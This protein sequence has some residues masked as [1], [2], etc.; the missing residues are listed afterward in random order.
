MTC[1]H[2]IVN[3][4]PY[5]YVLYEPYLLILSHLIL[6]YPTLSYLI[7][8]SLPPFL[9]YQPH[10]STSPL[11]SPFQF[12]PSFLFWFPFHSPL[13]YPSRRVT[14][15]ERASEDLRCQLVET[16]RTLDSLS[17]SHIAVSRK[18]IKICYL[19]ISLYHIRLCERSVLHILDGVYSTLSLSHFPFPNIF[20][21]LILHSILTIIFSNYN[22]YC[23]TYYQE[24]TSYAADRLS[25]QTELNDLTNQIISLKKELTEVQ[26]EL[27][28]KSSE[29]D[30]VQDKLLS[31]SEEE[32]R[33]REGLLQQVQ[34]MTCELL[35]LR[36]RVSRQGWWSY[37]W[38][39]WF[40][41]NI[42]LI[43]SHFILPLFNWMYCAD[44]AH[45]KAPHL[46]QVHV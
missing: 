23:F 34:E 36:N 3:E 42:G 33:V 22:H 31:E 44:V 7:F 28:L 9:F 32:S 12:F 21:W 25:L 46:S 45:L 16:Q 30:A 38:F 10:H 39:P 6:S 35:D 29:L 41:L 27:L 40:P 4:E 20:F 8:F 5:D 14:E 13:L 26:A 37:C 18:L 2:V 17:D 1:E 43:P 24:S 15:L 19:I 11:S